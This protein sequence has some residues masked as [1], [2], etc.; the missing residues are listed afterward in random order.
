MSR[1][2]KQA[3]VWSFI[4]FGLLVSLAFSQKVPVDI[5]EL[6]K[7][8]PRVFIDC[9]SYYCD[10]DY[11]RTEITFVNH[12][13]ERREAQVH[14]LITLQGTGSGGLE[15]TLSFSGQKEF[16]GMDETL[17]YFSHKADTEDEIRQ[18]LVRVLKVGLVR[19]VA[20]TPIVECVAIGLTEQPKPTSVVD[21]WNSW[22]FSLSADGFFSGEKSYTSKSI[23]GTFS[24]NRVTPEL[25]INAYL[26]ASRNESDFKVDEETIRSSS[27]SQSFSGLVV[28]SLGKHWSVGGFL[29]VQSSTYQNIKFALS[30]TPAVEYNLF[31]YSQST[32]RQ[33]RFLYRVGYTNARYREETIFDKV[34]E[35]LWNENL[36]GTLEVKEKWGTASASLEGSHYFHD[37]KKNRL[38]LDGEVSLRLYKGLSFNVYGSASRIHDQLSL[39]KGGASLEEILLRRKEQATTYQY[40]I[41]VGFSYTF[42]SVYSNVVNPRFGSGGRG[43]VRMF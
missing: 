16:K 18:G 31:P 24:A 9:Q 7:S 32:R 19:Y 42:G 38:V 40:F 29:A 11:V 26:S 28:K 34:K 3:T 12:V 41:M 5:E 30:L 6:K 25:K 10:L 21:K 33:L 43:I 27:S 35:N 4:F 15:F 14:V 22:V 23:Y 39:A 36:S 8:A 1:S 17:K 37:L 2:R 20:K 13:R